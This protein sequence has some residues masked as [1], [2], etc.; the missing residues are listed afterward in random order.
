MTATSMHDTSHFR[1]GM[2][3]R[4]RTSTTLHS[5]SPVSIVVIPSSSSDSGYK[6][7]SEL[8]EDPSSNSHARRPAHRPCIVPPMR[9]VRKGLPPVN[10]RLQPIPRQ[11]CS[12]PHHAFKKGYQSALQRHALT[13]RVG[14]GLARRAGAWPGHRNWHSYLSSP[15][16]STGRSVL[17]SVSSRTS[18]VAGFSAHLPRLLRN[19]P[20]RRVI[21]PMEPAAWT[22]LEST[23]PLPGRGGSWGPEDFSTRC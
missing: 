17:S 3:G 5:T 12:Y 23:E 13:R 1:R 15:A 20:R 10:R 2:S 7:S 9:P 18:S 8:S 21:R 14:E 11:P 6:A 4:S 19:R 22:S 16:S